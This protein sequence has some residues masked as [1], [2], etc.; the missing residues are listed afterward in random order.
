MVLLHPVGQLLSGQAVAGLKL[1]GLTFWRT[2]YLVRCC[3]A[4][5]LMPSNV[6]RVV[7]P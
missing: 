7:W 3:Y 4:R 1:Y 2:R 5:E 6:I